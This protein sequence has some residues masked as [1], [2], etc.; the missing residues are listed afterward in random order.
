MDVLTVPGSTNFL[1][2][3]LVFLKNVFLCVQL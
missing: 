3:V 2:L 1:I